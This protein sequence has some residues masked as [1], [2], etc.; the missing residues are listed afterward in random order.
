MDLIKEKEEEF[1]SVLVTPINQEDI[2]NVRMIE[3]E[4]RGSGGEIRREIR[5][6]L[7]PKQGEAINRLKNLGDFRESDIIKA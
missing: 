5:I 1:K 7:T 4:I 3:Q 6:N 2:N